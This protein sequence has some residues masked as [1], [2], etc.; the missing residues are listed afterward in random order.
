[1]SLA[2][3]KTSDE[4]RELILEYLYS[5]YKKSRSVSGAGV[6]RR[7]IKQVLKERGL[8]EQEIASNLYYL[9]QSGWVNE[10]RKTFPITR[11]STTIRAENISYRIADKGI[12][13]F[14]GPSKFQRTQKLTGINIT[15]IHGV[16]V[17]GDGNYVYNQYSNLYR[18][19]DLLGEE[20]RQT[21]RLSDEQKLNYQAEIETIKSQLLKP[22]PDRSILRTAWNVLKGVAT[23]GGIV[24]ALEKVRALI[25]PLLR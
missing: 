3:D 19:L 9:I 25:Q 21:D 14:E 8:N 18:S 7:E 16:T 15:N 6:K 12:N 17:I 13:H 23:V 20:I 5:K 22:N 11:G 4:I 2:L 10:E 24:S 1:M